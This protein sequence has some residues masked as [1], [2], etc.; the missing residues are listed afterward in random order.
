MCESDTVIDKLKNVGNPI[1]LLKMSYDVRKFLQNHQIV[2]LQ[3]EDFDRVFVDISGKTFECY[4][5]GVALLEVLPEKGSLIRISREALI[6][7][8]DLL[9]IE[10]EVGDDKSLL[11]NLL[12]DLRRVR[13]IRQYK[14]ILAIIDQTFETNLNI[15]EL[16][17][18]AINQLR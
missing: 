9:Q 2:F 1:S 7:V 10:F 13:N 17:K 11:S 12:T 4:D 3:T 6:Q 14:A 5:A 8:A 18:I 15:K 16:L